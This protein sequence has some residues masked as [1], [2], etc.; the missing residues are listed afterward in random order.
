MAVVAQARTYGSQLITVEEPESVGI[1]Q[2]TRDLPHQKYVAGIDSLLC[3]STR[4]RLFSNT[5][6]ILQQLRLEWDR[7]TFTSELWRPLMRSRAPSV[8]DH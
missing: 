6:S 2:A 3:L 4:V 1:N 7:V 5:L 8:G